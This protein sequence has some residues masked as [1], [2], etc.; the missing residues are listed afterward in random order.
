MP[1]TKEQIRAEALNL[2]P[3]ERETLAEE[4]LLS[5][6]GRERQAVD[7]A[8]L[9]ETRRRD[10]AFIA[11]KVNAKPVDQVIDRLNA[12]TRSYLPSS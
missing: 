3:L 1:L 6:D 4:L 5:I 11:G 12:Q 10:A 7:A 8:W 2:D 9:A